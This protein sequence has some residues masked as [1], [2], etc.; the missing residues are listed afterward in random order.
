M[1]GRFTLLLGWPQIFQLLEG[2]VS[3]LNNGTD[4]KILAYP[5]RFNIAPTQPILVL[6]R[7]GEKVEPFLMRWG[8]VPQ[9][10][11]NPADFP[12]IINARSETLAEKTSF[13][14]SLKNQ[15]CIIPASGYYEWSRLPDGTKIPQYITRNDGLPILMAGLHSTWVGE[16]GE[17][18]DTATIITI[19][20]NDDL[21]NVH[22]R[23]PVMLE[24]ENIAL[25]LDS[26]NVNAKEAQKL[27]IPIADG[28][29]KYHPVSTQV[30]SPKN[31]FETLIIPAFEMDQS[32]NK[33]EQVQKPKK[34][35]QLNLF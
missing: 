9:W 8:L 15:R 16:D 14:S 23:T 2:F 1:C 12:L 26:A 10:V 13:K 17:E 33:S 24:G 27:L 22:H 32:E 7:A 25:W 34:P 20:A 28:F 6:A 30:N 5:D 4:E 35:S 29:M 11:D 21:K 3:N 31:D 18:V 19:A